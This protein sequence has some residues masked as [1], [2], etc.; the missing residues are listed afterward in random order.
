MS[1]APG[2]VADSTA[3]LRAVANAYFAGLA[4]KDVSGVPYA[5]N[6]DAAAAVVISWREPFEN[7]SAS[8]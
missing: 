2:T 4:S 3:L 6:V 5:E 1:T 7:S 8:Q